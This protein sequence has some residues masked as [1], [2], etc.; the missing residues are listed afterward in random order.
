MPGRK[1]AG[2]AASA[3]LDVK[4]I[5]HPEIRVPDALH[6]P[7]KREPQAHADPIQHRAEESTEAEIFG[8]VRR[9]RNT[10]LLVRRIYHRF[11]HYGAA[12]ESAIAGARVAAW[13]RQADGDVPDAAAGV[14]LILSKLTFESFCDHTP[15]R[16]LAIEL[17]LASNICL[18]SR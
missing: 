13:P 4:P 2:A 15:M 16:P 14:N 9:L 5:E 8:H 17:S 7:Q 10:G 11:S 18:P 1:G 6:Q 3:R 12:R